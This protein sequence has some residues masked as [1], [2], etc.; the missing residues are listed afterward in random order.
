M[1]EEIE[2]PSAAQDRQCVLFAD[3]AGSTRMYGEYGDDATREMLIRC[4]DFMETIVTAHKGRVVRRIGDELLCLFAEPDPAAFA[5]I[6]LHTKLAQ[7]GADGSFKRPMR[8]R[9][10]FEAGPVQESGGAL[11][12]NSVHTAARVASLAK[13]GQTLTTRPTRDQLNPAVRCFTRP[14]DRVIL[15]GQAEEQEIFE[16]VW[17]VPTSTLVN[18]RA[19]TAAAPSRP[20]AVRVLLE[21]G[22]QRYQVDASNPR[23][24]IGRDV[25]CDLAVTG[26]SVSMVHGRVVWERGGPKYEDVSTNGTTIQPA[27]GAKTTARHQR[28]DLLGSGTLYLGDEPGNGG[29]S[30]Q[31]RLES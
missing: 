19:Q 7:A 28:V 27:E 11:F 24:E 8:A 20:R 1:K 31:Y 15:K 13:A 2:M 12:G 17:N 16:V 18:P 9:I 21:Y 5:S 10:G 29:A 30:V 14:Y 26:P 3:V 22:G 4:L 6:A 25:S 23:L